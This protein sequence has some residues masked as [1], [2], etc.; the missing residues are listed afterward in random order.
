MIQAKAQYS[1][2]LLTSSNCSDLNCTTVKCHGYLLVMLL[3]DDRFTYK[4]LSK[5][6][7]VVRATIGISATTFCHDDTW[8]C[9]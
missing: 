8:T 5:A 4:H 1:F 9:R 2:G 3:T 6:K 7:L